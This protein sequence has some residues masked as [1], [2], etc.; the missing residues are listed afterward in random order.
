MDV[1]NLLGDYPF[2]ATDTININHG[3]DRS[4]DVQVIIGGQESDDLILN[5][6]PLSADPTNQIV[7]KLRAA[8]TG[9]VQLYSL[10]AR[11]ANGPSAVTAAALEAAG[12]SPGDVFALDVGAGPD[13]LLWG[14]SSLVAALTVRYLTPGYADSV[15]E[16]SPIEFRMPVAGTFRNLRVRQNVV[17]GGANTLTYTLMVNGAPTALTVTMAST[18]SD[19]SD[20]ANSVAVAAGDLVAIRVTRSGV[21]PASPANV[22]AS[23][24]V[25]A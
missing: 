22:V 11:P 25:G 18:A 3:F 1:K 5:V 21:I 9:V 16:T 15:A 2:S 20:L 7:V 6:Y 4:V 12:A 23:L 17:G 8:Y 14:N 10:G 19:G 24:E 13:T